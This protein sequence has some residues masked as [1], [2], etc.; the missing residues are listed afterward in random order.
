MRECVVALKQVV[1]SLCTCLKLVK[2]S[3]CE[4][5]CKEE[6]MFL[7]VRKVLKYPSALE[8]PV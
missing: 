1:K 4:C 3:E 5:E 2:E 7:Q 6:D 8:L